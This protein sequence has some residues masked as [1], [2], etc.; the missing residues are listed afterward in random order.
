MQNTQRA[1]YG[2]YGISDSTTLPITPSAPV[3]YESTPTA[4]VYPFLGEYMGLELSH[5]MIAANMPEYLQGPSNVSNQSKV[6]FMI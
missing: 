4:P 5:D 6:N 3:E 1:S 2:S